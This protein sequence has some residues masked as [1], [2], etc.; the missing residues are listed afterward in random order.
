MSH[1]VPR[2][3]CRGEAEQQYGGVVAVVAL[4]L[5]T[6]LPTL[7]AGIDAP[8]LVHH[9]ADLLGDGVIYPIEPVDHELTVLGTIAARNDGRVI[10]GRN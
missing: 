9:V 6:F 5:A 8:I 7:R 2:Y 1:P 4:D 10:S 3:F